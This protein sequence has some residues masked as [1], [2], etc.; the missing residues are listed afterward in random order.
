[1]RKHKWFVFWMIFSLLVIILIFATIYFEDKKWLPNFLQAVG[2]VT[3][4]YLTLL[5]FLQ[6]K[7]ESDKQ[8]RNQLEHLQ[9]L[10]SRQ[11]NAL[12]ASTEKHINKLQEVTD[13]QISA[14]Q[15]LTE[16]QIDALQKTTFDQI[17]SFEKQISDVTNKLSENSILLA[18][19]LGRELEKSLD[20]YQ[21]TIQR[22]EAKY[23][24]LSNWKLLRTPEEKENQLQI[25]WNRIVQIKRG[26]EYLVDKYNK[27]REYLGY[28]QKRLN[29]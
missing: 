13:R 27:V 15:E 9:E 4:I 2:T 11:I 10:N 7:E 29:N 12:H 24:D 19:I 8:F 16:K 14:L 21:G 22:E 3:G 1:M 5:I 6:S 18:E 28:G 26:Y 23:K 25:Q 17:N 20:F